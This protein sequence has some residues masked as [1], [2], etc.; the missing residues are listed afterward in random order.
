MIFIRNAKEL[1]AYTV[2]IFLFS[3]NILGKEKKDFKKSYFGSILAGQIANYRNE[4]DIASEYFDYANKFNP[5]NKQI[6]NQSLMSLILSG[7]VDEAIKKIEK[8]KLLSQEETYKSQ[9]TDLLSFIKLVKESKNSEALSYLANNNKILITDKVKPI[10]K[11]WLA[12]SF[13]NAKSEIDQFEYKSDGLVMSDI[14]F[15]HL[16]L[17]NN[18][19]KD[20][21]NAINI[22]EKTLS[23]GID[24]R[25]R[26]MFFYKNLIDDK[27]EENKII[28]SFV[29]KNPSHSFN[30]YIN[31]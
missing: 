18:L 19:Y 8:Y 1:L 21:V 30:I 29:N 6:F 13:S 10:L 25:L 7:K 24:N 2:I 28:K 5:K 15:I 14:Y 26:H 11:A 4:T 22:F 23:S 3:H 27:V 31:K 17:I 9:I 12:D 20:K 16:A